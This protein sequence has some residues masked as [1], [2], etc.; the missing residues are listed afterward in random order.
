M[1]FRMKC[2][3]YP[4]NAPQKHFPPTAFQRNRRRIPFV[5]KTWRILQQRWLQKRRPLWFLICSWSVS[6][7]CWA[8]QFFVSEMIQIPATLSSVGREKDAGFPFFDGG[9]DA[10]RRGIKYRPKRDGPGG[11]DGR[12]GENA[13]SAIP[14]GRKT[15]SDSDS[16][17]HQS[18]SQSLY[19]GPA[20]HRRGRQTNKAAGISSI[21]GTLNR[22]EGL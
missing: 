9:C 12:C 15:R 19:I 18:G 3:R 13:L 22:N 4:K 7:G 14:D 2:I 5:G 20:Q 16:V 17:F 1:L 8:K 10:T 21:A 6:K 11:G